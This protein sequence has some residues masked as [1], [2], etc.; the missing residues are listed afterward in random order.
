MPVDRRGVKIHLTNNMNDRLEDRIYTYSEYIKRVYKTKTF[1]VGLSIGKI[2]PHRKKGGCIYCNPHT[3]IDDYQSR[4]ADINRQIEEGIKKLQE[5]CDAKNFIAY[6]QDETSTAGDLEFLRKKFLKAKNHPKIS[7]IVISTR[8]DYIDEKIVKLIKELNYEINVEIGMQSASDTSLE[9]LN[10]GHT[11]KQ[12]Q[13]AIELLGKNKIKVGVHLIFGIPGETKKDMIET[14][15]YVSSNGYINQIKFHNLVPYKNTK[16]GEMILKGEFKPYSIEEHIE[17]LS[18]VLPYVRG[19]IVIS[20]LFTSNIRNTNLN[21]IGFEGN[22]TKWMNKLRK[23]LIKKDIIQ[24]M[25][26]DLIY[27]RTRDD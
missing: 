20:R 19:D 25:K 2:C 6:F 7:G 21:I 23:I 16:Y 18:E 8:P 14:V 5:C 1:R 27:K 22:K 9:F 15:K 4:Y 10:R 13:E 26:T 17:N 12:T 24:G 11:F 3:F